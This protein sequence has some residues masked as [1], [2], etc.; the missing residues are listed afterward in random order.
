[1]LLPTGATRRQIHPQRPGRTRHDVLPR[2]AERR[3]VSGTSNRSRA[4]GSSENV[5]ADQWPDT[6]GPRRFRALRVCIW[7]SRGGFKPTGSP[8]PDC[9][10]RNQKTIIFW[11]MQVHARWWSTTEPAAGARLPSNSI[12]RIGPPV[13][14]FRIPHAQSRARSPGA[15][16]FTLGQRKMVGNQPLRRRNFPCREDRAQPVWCWAHELSFTHPVHDR[17]KPSR[18]ATGR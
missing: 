3:T 1:M 2:F 4:S 8:R 12:V 18:F 9:T 6:G 14:R 10:M 16:P 5:D 17:L 11:F 7:P 15:L 13:C